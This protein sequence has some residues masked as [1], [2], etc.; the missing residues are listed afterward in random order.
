M[1]QV[2]VEAT[3]ANTSVHDVGRAD[4]KKS[5]E[6]V[7]VPPEAGQEAAPSEEPQ[8][9]QDR[10]MEPAVEAERGV[11]GPPPVIQAVVPA[12]EALALPQG[13]TL[14]LIDLTLDDSLANKGKQEADIEAVEALDGAGTSAALGGDQAKVSAGWLDFTELA[15]VRAEEELP[16]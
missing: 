13:S 14:A 8:P 4:A 1:T 3:E 7:E 12:V 16:R 15:L 2:T 6:V 5:K 11:V 10:P 9:Q